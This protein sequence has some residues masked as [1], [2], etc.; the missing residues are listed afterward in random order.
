MSLLEFI[1]KMSW[2]IITFHDQMR[3]LYN[4]DHYKMNEEDWIEIFI[5]HY[6]GD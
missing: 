6:K 1:K 2:A 5:A 4:G 3:K